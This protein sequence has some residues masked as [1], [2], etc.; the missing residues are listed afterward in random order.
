M[1]YYRAITMANDVKQDAASLDLA[2]LP[3]FEFPAKPA[4][5]NITLQP[6]PVPSPHLLETSTFWVALIGLIGVVMTVLVG[7]WRMRAELKHA[8]LVRQDALSEASASRALSI[9][10]A[11]A[12]RL[13]S[14]AE[15]H[16]ERITESRRKVYLVAAQQVVQSN[17]LIAGLPHKVIGDVAILD[18][19]KDLGVAVAQIAILGNMETLLKSRALLGLINKLFFKALP[20]TL[21]IASLKTDIAGQTRLY[22]ESEKNSQRLSLE[23]IALADGNRQHSIDS[24]KLLAELRLEQTSA[25]ALTDNMIELQAKL[26]HQQRLYLEFVLNG[27]EEVTTCTDELIILMRQE[28][29]LHTDTVAL[30]ESTTQ[31]RLQ[32]RAAMS[33]LNATID[34]I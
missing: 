31:M 16:R 23:L 20:R 21:P 7:V 13:H 26:N 24:A 12:N 32:L 4:T 28:L 11:L 8:A 18:Q 29:E 5:V 3:G 30:T 9:E 19:L 6:V 2:S 15:A 25:S 22:E 34:S 10:E 14:S 27:L 1:L 33:E 17:A